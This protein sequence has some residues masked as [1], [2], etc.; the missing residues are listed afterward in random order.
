MSVIAGSSRVW[1]WSDCLRP[2]SK[3]LQST[4]TMLLTP[5]EMRDTLTAYQK[6]MTARQQKMRDEPG[7]KGKVGAKRSSPQQK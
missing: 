6:D 5:G 4:G 3:D 2:R 1:R 7:A